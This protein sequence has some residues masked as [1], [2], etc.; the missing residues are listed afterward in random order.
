MRQTARGKGLAD[1]GES[2]GDVQRDKLIVDLDTKLLAKWNPRRWSDKLELSS[3]PA[4]PL[5]PTVFQ[6][7]G[8]EPR[9]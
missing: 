3:D 2:T 6:V 5:F 9:T 1:G 4:R 8:V 7:V